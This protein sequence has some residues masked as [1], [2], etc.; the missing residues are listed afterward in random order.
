[1][2]L[3]VILSVLELSAR[4]YDFFNPYCK[5]KHENMVYSDVPYET[6]AKIC[7][8]WLSLLWFWDP[9]TGLYV[10]EPNQHKETVNIN[11]F[12][13]RGPEISQEKQDN[14]YRIFVVG[15]STTISL[16]APSDELTHPGFLQEKFD[17]ANLDFE[18]EVINAGIPSFAS[19]QELDL[20][21]KKL[22]KFQPDLIIVYDGSNDINLP[23]GYTP[24]KTDLRTLIADG[25]N[26]YVPFWET[27][28][29]LYHYL[30]SVTENPTPYSFDDSDTHQKAVLWQE[31][32]KKVCQLG[33]ENNFS[34]LIIL[35]PILGT[36]QKQLTEHE[37]NQHRLFEHEKVV[38]AYDL[39][40]K[41]L[42]D[43][44]NHCTKIAD[45]RNIFDNVTDDVYFDNTHVG[46]QSNKIIADRIYDEVLPII[47]KK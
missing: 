25:F 37:K 41:E 39:F 36:G 47:L 2:F 44:S 35:Q 31:N 34:T 18:V 1:M 30:S 22:I 17:N 7:E 4:T 27:V 40:S 13:F 29:V 10:L 15:G 14:T 20:I 26:R 46:Y 8:S 21:Q 42:N 38:P 11:S 12:G 3:F 24:A 16:R 32:L 9:E 23:Y 5:L 28:P 19:T 43:L 6:K 45:F 33:N